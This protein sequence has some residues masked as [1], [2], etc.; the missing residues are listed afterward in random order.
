VSGKK[1]LPPGK[2]VITLRVMRLVTRSVTTT[3]PT[4][5]AG[6]IGGSSL[7]PLRR[8]DPFLRD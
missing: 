8:L 4:F 5:L 6:V 7:R 3:G 2:V 1:S